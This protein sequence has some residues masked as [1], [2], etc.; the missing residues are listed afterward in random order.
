MNENIKKSELWVY[1]THCR[2]NGK[3]S[4]GY[5]IT[6]LNAVRKHFGAFIKERTYNK[7]VVSLK[8]KGLINQL[9]TNDEKILTSFYKIDKAIEIVEGK[10]TYNFPFHC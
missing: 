8:N 10:K 2:H 1:L 9:N 4:R 6:S 7:C 5:S 3:K